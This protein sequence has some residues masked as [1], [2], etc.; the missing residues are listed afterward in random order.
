LSREEWL[1]LGLCVCVL[2]SCG[3]IQRSMDGH[4]RRAVQQLLDEREIAS[5]DRLAD[6]LPSERPV[7]AAGPSAWRN[8]EAL[9]T[10]GVRA[11][12]EQACRWP[13]PVRMRARLRF[14]PEEL[15]GPASVNGLDITWMEISCRALWPQ[16]PWLW[17]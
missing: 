3:Q 6:D 17:N 9:A 16:H 5:L 14:E 12:M 2:P 13:E 8:L 1:R 11:A 10:G 4:F 7:F 15:Q